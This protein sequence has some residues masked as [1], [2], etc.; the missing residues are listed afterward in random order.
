LAT[1]TGQEQAPN[2]ATTSVGDSI[3]IARAPDTPII[4]EALPTPKELWQQYDASAKKFWDSALPVKQDNREVLSFPAPKPE[5]DRPREPAKPEDPSQP[6]LPLLSIDGMVER[7]ADLKSVVFGNTSTYPD[8]KVNISESDRDFRT[9]YVKSIQEMSRNHGLTDQ[10][11]QDA[12]VKLY[13]F[14][15]GGDGGFDTVAGMT[16]KSVSGVIDTIKSFFTDAIPLSDHKY[17][18]TNSTA[19]GYKQLIMATTMSN[20]FTDGKNMST[21][22]RE[23]A[24]GVSDPQERDR[25]IAKA[26]LIGKLP[27]TMM[28]HAR[29]SYLQSNPKI[30]EDPLYKEDPEKYW[31]KI[32]PW[33]LFNALSRSANL[34]E[35]PGG[36]TMTGREFAS[37]IHGLNVDN[38]L[39]PMIQATQFRSL[40]QDWQPDSTKGPEGNASANLKISL[41]TFVTHAQDQIKQ[42]DESPVDAK[43]KA[44]NT[45]LDQTLKGKSLSS[46]ETVMRDAVVRKMTESLRSGTDPSLNEGERKFLF[47]NLLLNK[48]FLN[49][50]IDGKS[51]ADTPEGQDISR[52]FYKLNSLYYGGLT[53]ERLTPAVFELANLIGAPQAKRMLDPALSEWRTTNFVNQGGYNANAILANRSAAEVLFAINRVQ[54]GPKADESRSGIKAFR[55]LFEAM[56]R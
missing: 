41:D 20:I 1:G 56:K 27:D 51:L 31:A 15:T 24:N 28:L 48:V 45:I 46:I 43:L 2:D 3:Q 14:E 25:L 11:V 36:G 19:I 42:F 12:I 35:L 17:V 4:Y 10:Q 23:R 55:E 29:D 30:K 8:L 33:T 47:D 54:H 13:A 34:I 50:G 52:L 16:K 39:G 18:P 21:Q 26:D 38:D 40:I 53:A 22:L 6:K 37:S 32:A 49:P 44:F 5:V 9:Q 7:F